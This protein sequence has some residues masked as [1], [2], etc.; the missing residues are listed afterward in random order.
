MHVAEKTPAIIRGDRG[1]LVQLCANLIE[2]SLRHAPRGVLITVTM[3]R[4]QDGYAVNIADDGQ[5]IPEAERGNVFRRFY[6]VEPAMSGEGHGLG[7]SLVA[8]IADLHGASI[9]LEDNTPGLRVLLHFPKAEKSGLTEKV[10]AEPG[11]G[12]L[13]AADSRLP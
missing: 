1:L 9:E 4:T 13:K 6:R 10:N 11:A 5:G 7:L 12:N 3:S 2:N 8:A